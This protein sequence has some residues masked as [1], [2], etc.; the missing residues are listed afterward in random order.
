[1]PEGLQR[2]ARRAGWRVNNERIREL[3]RE[4]G[5]RVSARVISVDY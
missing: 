3:W 2:M 1:M 4:E 5:L